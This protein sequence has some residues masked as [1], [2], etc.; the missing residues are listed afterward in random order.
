MMSLYKY[1]ENTKSTNDTTFKVAATE[2]NLTSIEEDE[3]CNVLESVSKSD[4]RKR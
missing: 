1:F 2:A 4:S 3:I